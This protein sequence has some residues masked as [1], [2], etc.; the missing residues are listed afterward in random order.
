MDSFL[1]VSPAMGLGLNMT[2][3]YS[4]LHTNTSQSANFFKTFFGPLTP[5]TVE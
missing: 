4:A 5:V 1:L 3:V 2:Q